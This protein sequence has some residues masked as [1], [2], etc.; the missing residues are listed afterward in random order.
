MRAST[1]TSRASV[2]ALFLATVNC[3]GGSAIAVG[4]TTGKHS[5]GMGLTPAAGHD[6][7]VIQT[8]L[9]IYIYMWIITIMNILSGG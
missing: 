8:P 5:H 1:L 2:A 4:S 9:S 6:R 3:S 7:R